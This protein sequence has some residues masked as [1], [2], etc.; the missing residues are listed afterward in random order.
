[1][2]REK[3]W[4]RRFFVKCGDGRQISADNVAHYSLTVGAPSPA[5]VKSAEINHHYDPNAAEAKKGKDENKKQEQK[6]KGAF[7]PNLLLTTHNYH[8]HEIELLT[9]IFAGTPV[10]QLCLDGCS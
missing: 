5:L 9:D 6:D 10:T 8:H 2:L 7:T 1:M 4:A 3:L